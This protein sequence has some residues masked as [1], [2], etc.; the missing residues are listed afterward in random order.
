MT[1]YRKKPV[2]IEA[3][4]FTG[5]TNLN[6]VVPDWF[7]SAVLDGRV[8]AHPD[9]IEIQTLEGPLRVVP[10]AWIIRGVKGEL[11]PCDDEI[12]RMTYDEER[13]D[14]VDA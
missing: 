1:R 3:F 8:K 11:Y 2:V 4:Q 13:G 5:G 7:V 12:F 10:G 14:I 9:C 6:P